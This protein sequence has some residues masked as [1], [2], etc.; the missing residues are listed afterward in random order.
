MRE[1]HLALEQAVV[2]RKN[3]AKSVAMSPFSIG[4]TLANP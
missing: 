4:E 2:R 1:P 3:E